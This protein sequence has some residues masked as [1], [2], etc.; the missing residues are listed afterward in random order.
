MHR[1]LVKEEKF[2]KEYDFYIQELFDDQIISDPNVTN[3]VF[4]CSFE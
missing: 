2:Q 1:S 3:S 4:N